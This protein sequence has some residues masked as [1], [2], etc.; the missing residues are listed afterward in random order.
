[1]LYSSLNDNHLV[2]KMDASTTNAIIQPNGVIGTLELHNSL[3]HAQRTPT[4]IVTQP[5]NT[6]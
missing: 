5:S 3:L 6:E 2:T 4:G 1:M